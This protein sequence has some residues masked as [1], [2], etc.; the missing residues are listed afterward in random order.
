MES[1]SLAC[2]NSAS[3][4]GNRKE[5]RQTIVLVTGSSSVST[6][7]DLYFHVKD[8]QNARIKATS[9]LVST[10]NPPTVRLADFGG[11]FTLLPILPDRLGLVEPLVGG[12]ARSRPFP[13]S[14]G[15]G[16]EG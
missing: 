13:L 8:T 5:M 12:G 16:I 10:C 14:G 9:H 1:K 2:E 6:P 15:V 7:V 11:G 3:D 4:V